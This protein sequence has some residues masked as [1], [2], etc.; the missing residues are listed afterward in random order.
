MRA[1]GVVRTNWVQSHQSERGHSILDCKLLSSLCE[2]GT[3]GL[4]VGWLFLA[5]RGV[6]RRD[7]KRWETGLGWLFSWPVMPN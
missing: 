4:W 6:W 3:R 1:T 5:K 2:L 7:G